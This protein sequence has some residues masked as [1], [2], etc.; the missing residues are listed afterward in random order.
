MT[1]QTKIRYDVYISYNEA[2]A[3]WVFDWLLPRLK[4]AGLTVAIDAES[5]EPGAPVLEETER[6][7]AESRSILAILSPAY[8]AAGWDN[9]ET[10][11]VQSDDPGARF[12]RLIPLLLEA[13]DPPS[14]IKLLHWVDFTDAARSQEQLE[15]VLDAVRGTS[16]LPELHYERIPDVRQRW[17]EVRWLAVVGVVAAL[18]LAL[19]AWL[20]WNQRPDPQPTAMP[21]STFNIAVAE[22]AARDAA[23]SAPLAV[24]DGRDRAQGVVAYL[25]DQKSTLTSA[26]AQDVTIW[27]PN[28]GVGAISAADVPS[29]T[30]Q[31][32][33][34]V[35]IYGTLWARPGQR[36]ELE[37]HFYLASAGDQ[38]ATARASELHGRF[39]LGK[40]I[41]YA[42]DSSV[43]PGDV[44]DALEARLE[45]LV[46]LLRGLVRLS[47]QNEAGYRL[48]EESF[49]AATQT[50]WGRGQGEGQEILYHFLGNAYL[51]QA[52]FAEQA[53]TPI[54]QRRAILDKAYAAF[55]TAYQLNDRYVRALNGRGGA[56]YQLAR[57]P[58]FENGGCAWDWDLLTQAELDF[59]RVLDTPPD[60]KIDAGDLDFNALYSLAR[61]HLTR[62]FCGDAAA[63]ESARE[64]YQ[65]VVALYDADPTNLR[66]LSMILVTRELAHTTFY[67]P[68]NQPLAPDSPL[69]GEIVD[70]YEQSVQLGE[71]IGTDQSLRMA[72]DSMVFLLTALCRGERLDALAP[73]IDD[74]V[75]NFADPPS[76]RAQIVRTA[77]LPEE[78]QDV[79]AEP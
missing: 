72:Q 48:A 63:W 1:E 65:A 15:R 68:A 62:A 8:V 51:Q 13:C 55:D 21:E 50:Q 25:N 33:A 20:V 44:N 46:H 53:G 6:V 24:A 79:I 70:L 31:L 22:F 17:W 76:V 27:G 60:A 37:P 28:E 67:D 74:F 9:F 61:S 5:F 58:S 42:A 4:D 12:R 45:A 14:R 3:E 59:Q 77:S 75:A 36:W 47:E 41:S 10:L 49:L 2:N 54:E 18:T 43:G 66:R 16:A 32:K 40:P 69:L 78:C 38:Q 56:T 64:R 7:I 26:L 30:E 35:L 23:D 19:V 71:E 73:T 39:A 29:R 52:S 11:L 57:L 34:D